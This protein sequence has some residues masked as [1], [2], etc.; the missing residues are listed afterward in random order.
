ML[1]VSNFNSDP[2]TALRLQSRHLYQSSQNAVDK[3]WCRFLNVL[4][5]IGWC[6][7]VAAEREAEVA[8]AAHYGVQMGI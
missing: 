2:A 3:P 8:V 1:S 4:R 5:G 7:M 6:G